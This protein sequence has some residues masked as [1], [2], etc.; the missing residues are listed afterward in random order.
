MTN[1]FRFLKQTSAEVS[2]INS[3]FVSAFIKL[4]GLTFCEKN[5]LSH[6][7]DIDNKILESFLNTVSGGIDLERLVRLF[8]FV[9]SLN[10]DTVISLFLSK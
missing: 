3:L 5:Y 9:I 2:Y 4:N 6:Y 7:K 8:E 1:V 10:S